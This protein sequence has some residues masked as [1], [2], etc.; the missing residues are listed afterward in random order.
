[1]ASAT[2]ILLS[3]FYLFIF[4]S[5]LSYFSLHH[6]SLCD[7]CILREQCGFCY[8]E[9]GGAYVNG[10]GSCL[11]MN[12]MHMSYSLVGRCSE[13]NHTAGTVWADD[14]CPTPYGFLAMIGMALYLLA[15]APGR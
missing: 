13:N 7:S 8:K 5:F 3:L 15:F 9:A 6:F 12:T 4:S 10:S 1:M 2:I 14:F 11:P